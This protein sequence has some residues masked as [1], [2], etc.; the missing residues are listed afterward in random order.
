MKRVGNIMPQIADVDNLM[1][2]FC[3]ARRGKQYKA[4]VIDYSANVLE[5]I[6]SLRERMLNETL[7]VGNYHYFEI[8]DPK[9][10]R[11]CAASFEERVVHHAIMNVCKERFERHLIFDTYATR[12]NKGVYAAIDRVREAICKYPYVAK[13]DV[14][15]YFDSIN[16]QVLKT[17][18]R[19]IFKDQKLLRLFDTIIDSYESSPST[20]IPIGNL[21]SQYFANYYLSDL[22]HYI[23]EKLHVPVYVRYMDDMLLFAKSRLE[24]VDMVAKIRAYAENI[25]LLE[26]KPAQILNVNGGVSFLGYSLAPHRIWLNRRSKLRFVSKFR[27]YDSLLRCGEWNEEQFIQHIRPLLAFAEKAYTMNLRER[28]CRRYAVGGW[29]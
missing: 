29:E 22:D 6:M 21:T 10:R 16:H 13:L 19:R 4:E 14:R 17:K 18:L 9:Q 1:L 7:S 28:V 3:K 2:A 15:K 24:L 11:I 23:K 8:Y 20:G 25:L 5:N 12:E 26:L 27:I